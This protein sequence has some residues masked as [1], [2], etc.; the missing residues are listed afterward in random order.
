MMRVHGLQAY[1]VVT[2][3]LHEVQGNLCAD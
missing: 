2:V 1:N 3:T